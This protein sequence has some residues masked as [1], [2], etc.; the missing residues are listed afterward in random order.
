MMAKTTNKSLEFLVETNRYWAMDMDMYQ[1][2]LTPQKALDDLDIQEREKLDF[3]S[4]Y[5]PESTDIYDSRMQASGWSVDYEK[6]QRVTLDELEMKVREVFADQIARDEAFERRLAETKVIV[7]PVFEENAF[8]KVWSYRLLSEGTSYTVTR[9]AEDLSYGEEPGGD[10]ITLSPAFEP[11]A[12]EETRKVIN[13]AISR[14]KHTSKEPR[15]ERGERLYL[16]EKVR[17]V[18]EKQ[19]EVEGSGDESYA[20]SLDPESCPCPDSEKGNKCKHIFAALCAERE[21]A[22]M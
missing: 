13:V 2:V 7:G 5:I 3:V 11:D 14:C 12:D 1:E 17:R 18:G 21:L 16:D 10:W 8:Q 9:A 19:Y 15:E 4:R 20:V 6:G 22:A